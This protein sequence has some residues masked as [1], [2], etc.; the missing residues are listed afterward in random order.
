MKKIILSIA[1]V[2]L[3][4]CSYAQTYLPLSGGILTGTLVLNGAP[5]VQS[6]TSGNIMASGSSATV[7]GTGSGTDYLSYIYGNNPFSIWTNNQRRLIIDGT[8]NVGIGTTSPGYKLDI[9]KGATGSALNITGAAVGTR[10]DIGMDFSAV[11]AVIATYARIGL[12]ITT[13][14][15]GSETGGLTFSTV[16]NGSLTEKMF[17]DGAGKVGIGTT[18]PTSKFDIY[19]NN[20]RLHVGSSNGD[21]FMGQ[22][23]AVNNRI[24][25]TGR[26]LYFTTYT[27]A[28]NFGISGNTSLSVANTGNVLIGQTTQTNTNYKL[29]INGSARANEIVVNSTGADFVFDKSYS[30]PKLSDVK[31]YI[32]ANQHLPEIPSA[33]EMQTNGMSVGK[34]NTK[35]LQKIEE[36]TLYL[37]QQKEEN[38]KLK[39]ENGTLKENQQK[40]DQAQEARIAI[41][42]KALLKLTS[43]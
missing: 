30:L 8:G 19:G 35:L 24:E 33:K 3:G 11:N 31:K 4:C 20:E 10:N 41:L 38:E 23:D 39:A 9:Y 7:L 18:S 1:I 42:E 36:L 27:G 26:S 12:Q 6:T 16:N 37:I 22:W 2:L 15:T 29:D 17:I 14:T 32:E 21:L 28:I 5:F 43:K 40:V 13:G 34:I 25:S